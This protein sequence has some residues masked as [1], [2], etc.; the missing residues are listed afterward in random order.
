M[1]ASRKR[2]NYQCQ[3]G[4]FHNNSSTLMTSLIEKKEGSRATKR[5]NAYRKKMRAIKAA[6]SI[7][8]TS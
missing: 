5:K 8:E 3:N 1:A 4:N 7:D 6:K 2:D